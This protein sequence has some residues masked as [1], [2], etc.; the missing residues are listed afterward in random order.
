MKKRIVDL[1]DGWL[2][3]HFDCQLEYAGFEFVDSPRK[4]LSDIASK[5]GNAHPEQ[6]SDARAGWLGFIIEIL[7]TQR[8]DLFVLNM[9]PFDAELIRKIRSDPS[10]DYIPILILTCNSEASVLAAFS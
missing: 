5:E 4:P 3:M 1:I 2:R 9:V 8:I 10:L 6:K 7:R